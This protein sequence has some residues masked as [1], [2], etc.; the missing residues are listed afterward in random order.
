VS[1]DLK[2]PARSYEL[3]DVVFLRLVDFLREVGFLRAVVFLLTVLLRAVFFL[4][5]DVLFRLP[6]L[7]P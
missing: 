5:L 2:Q 7:D 1:R 3:R 4:L 6:E